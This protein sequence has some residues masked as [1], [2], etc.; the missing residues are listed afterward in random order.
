ML[1]ITSRSL[2]LFTQSV[3]SAKGLFN[4]SFQRRCPSFQVKKLLKVLVLC[5]RLALYMLTSLKTQFFAFCWTI[6][7]AVS[8]GTR[9]CFLGTA[10]VELE[11]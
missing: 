11:Y 2:L 8:N 6:R 5:S 7:V 3:C 10:A 4:V 9:F 1:Q